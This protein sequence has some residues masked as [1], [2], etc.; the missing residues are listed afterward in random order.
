MARRKNR[1]KKAQKNQ[2]AMIT[3][4]RGKN[5]SPAEIFGAVLGAAILIM[6][7]VIIVTALLG[8]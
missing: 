1:K 6:F 3:R 2:R 7:G 8:E 5:Y 4:G